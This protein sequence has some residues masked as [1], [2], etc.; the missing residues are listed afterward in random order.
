MQERQLTTST[1]R[2]APKHSG[3]QGGGAARNKWGFG[4]PARV[5]DPTRGRRAADDL[6]VP[7]PGD[8]G[9]RERKSASS[10]S[11]IVAYPCNLLPTDSNGRSGVVALSRR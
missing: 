2:A 6:R 8:P 5:R 11:Q 4:A 9:D 3:Y 7:T 1:A 10:K